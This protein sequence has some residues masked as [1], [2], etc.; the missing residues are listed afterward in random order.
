MLDGRGGKDFIDGGL[1]SDTAL[2]TDKTLAVVAALNGAADVTVTVGGALEDTLRG[3]E[4]LTGGSGNDI[5]GGDGQANVLDGG[6]GDDRLTGGLGLDTLDGGIGTDT[7]VYAD[8]NTAV[9]ATLNGATKVTVSVGGFVEDTI[10]NIENLI[11]GSAAD[12]LTGDAN[13]NVFDGGGG[14]DL[15]MGAGGLDVLDGGLG[16]DTVSF[17]DK[18]Q[19]VSLTL[20]GPLDIAAN[21]GGIVE[22]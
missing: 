10:A 19:A 18:T 4:N 12:T 15:L 3:I 13:A 2:F 22:D 20:A 17:A 1:G 6:S 9:V 8:R 16:S 5:L 7:A 11:G 21:V 14:D